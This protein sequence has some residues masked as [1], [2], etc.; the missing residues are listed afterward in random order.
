MSVSCR[1]CGRPAEIEFEA[2]DRNVLL[3]P[4]RFRYARCR[5][6]GTLSLVDV[7]ADLRRYYPPQHYGLMK[8][9]ERERLPVAEGQ[10]VAL[11]GRRVQ[12]GRLIE[13][14]TGT[15]AFAYAARRAGFE[16]TGIEL[17]PH[18]CRHL[19]TTIGV[20][21]IE[22]DDPAAALSQLPP[23]RAIAMWHVLEHLAD[24]GAVLDAAA[25]RLEPGGVLALSTP[26][27]QSLQLR[28]LGSRWTHVDAPRHLV[29]VPLATLT[30]R[31][32]AAGLH[33][34]QVTT[35]DRTGRQ[36]NWQGWE[37]AMLGPRAGDAPK[38][39]VAASLGMLLAMR[40]IEEAGLR[41]TT[42]TAVFAKPPV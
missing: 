26:N 14:G 3:G 41:G 1:F 4:E 27:P 5:N 36:C 19:R 24:P 21:A 15:G 39:A 11:I 13:I 25:R 2:T 6:C 34:L 22:S 7:P 23:A 35:S 42:Y 10:K 33:C 12:P 16:V 29:L 40:P 30:R 8:A 32:A 37:R 18:A 20:E 17:D 28:L 31:A 9:S 38:L